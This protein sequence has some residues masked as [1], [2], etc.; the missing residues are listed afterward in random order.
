MV[1]MGVS[2]TGITTDIDGEARSTP[3]DIGA[4]EVQNPIVPGN[5]QF[6]SPTYSV[7]ENAGPATLTITRTGGS[8]GAISA[9]FST[10]NGTATGGSS[11]TPGVDFISISG[12][13]VNWANGDSAPKTFN[14][15]ICNDAAFEG[16]EAFSSTITGTTGGA[17]IGAPAT[18]TVTINDDDLPSAGS[19]SVNDVRLFEGNSG[20][21]FIVFT[22]TLTGGSGASSVNY[23]TANGTATGGI[24]Y[25]PQAGTL[26]FSA[27]NPVEESGVIT[28]RTLT[29]AIPVIGDTNKEAN[30]TFVLNLNTPVNATIADGQGVGII[31]DEDRP[32]VSDFDRDKLSDLSVFRPNEGN[33]YI[34]ETASGIPRVVNFGLSSDLPVPGDY[35]GDGAIDIA[36]RRPS[37]GDWYILQSSNGVVVTTNFGL[38]TDK[39]VQG[40]Y[41]GD[42]KTDIAIYRPS[43]GEWWVRKSSDGTTFVAHFGISTDLP[44]QGDYDG[45]AKTDIAVYRNGVWYVTRSSDSQVAIVNFGLAGDK[46]VSGDF[47]GDGKYDFAV[48]RNGTWWILYSLTGNALTTQFGFPTDIPAPADYDRDGTT[49]ITVFRPSNGDWYILRSSTNSTLQVHF[50]QSGDIPIASAYLPQ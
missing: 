34:F 11:C 16:S 14:V 45:D 21:Q 26:N 15:T 23:A 49:D 31:I 6:S 48:Y 12:G 39:Q 47:D 32:Y 8:D 9:T 17:I 36:L 3:P 42:G 37:T 25:L 41:D 7:N 43:A 44:V 50:G 27:L 13:S 40:D 5:V 20:T 4:D 46:P 22:V 29:V 10:A 33:W 38:S 1:N 19:L 18:A 35:D 28:T 30:E 2:G 24:D